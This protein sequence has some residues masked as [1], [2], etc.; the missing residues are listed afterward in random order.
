MHKTCYSVSKELFFCGETKITFY[1]YGFIFL[2]IMKVTN[3]TAAPNIKP[4]DRK[5]QENPV[6]KND[7]KETDLNSEKGNEDELEAEAK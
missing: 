4:D 6:V 3:V 5:V 2:P 7:D 1:N